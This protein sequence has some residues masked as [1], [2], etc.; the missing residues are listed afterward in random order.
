MGLLLA[1]IFYGPFF[2]LLFFLFYDYWAFFFRV[3]F[4]FLSGVFAMLLFLI[5]LVMFSTASIFQFLGVCPRLLVYGEF[6]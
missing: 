3:F 5:A 6:L 1:A 4:S 2:F